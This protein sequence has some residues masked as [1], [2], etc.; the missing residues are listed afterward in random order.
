MSK[1]KCKHR[2]GT[3]RASVENQY[4]HKAITAKERDR[5]EVWLREWP[6]LEVVK[7]S[8]RPIGTLARIAALL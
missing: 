4:G 6:I 5:I 2:G 1:P 3:G 7:L 8:G